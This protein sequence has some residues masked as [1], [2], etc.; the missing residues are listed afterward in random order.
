MILKQSVKAPNTVTQCQA[1]FN[2]SSWKYANISILGIKMLLSEEVKDLANCTTLGR[3]FCTEIKVVTFYR[4]DWIEC[5]IIKDQATNQFNGT[6][7]TVPASSLSVAIF[8]GT[9]EEALLKSSQSLSPVV[10]D[11]GRTKLAFEFVN[12]SSRVVEG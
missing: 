1:L 4:G 7:L 11:L 10:S 8:S 5:A 9:S 3:K 12:G 2:T 6:S